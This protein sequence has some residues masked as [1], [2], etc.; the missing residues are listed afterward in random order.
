MDGGGPIRR[1]G[2]DELEAFL[3]A[4]R[5]GSLTEAAATLRI[6]KTAV[7][8]RLRTL[9]ALIGQRLLDRGPRGATL[10]E[11]GRRL[12]PDVQAFL[13]ESER[14]FGRLGDLRANSDSWSISGLRSLSGSGAPSTEQVLRET[15]HLFAEIFH[16]IDDAVAVLDASHGRVLEANR[17]FAQLTGRPREELLGCELEELGIITSSDFG[18]LVADAS[19]ATDRA[20]IVEVRSNRDV[21]QLEFWLRPVILRGE[22]R[23]L[24]V[25]R[26][27][28]SRVRR[29]R[30]LLKR[31]A[32][33]Q[34][35][36]D[37][38]LSVL[39][40]EP[41]PVVF[42]RSAELLATHLDATFSVIWE[43]DGD[44]LLLRSVFGVS[45]RQL[46]ALVGSP[47]SRLSFM[48]ALE[49]DGEVVSDDARRDPRFERESIRAL[50]VRSVAAFRAGASGAGLSFVVVASDET[51]AFDS[52]DLDFARAVAN[53]VGL[54]VRS[55]RRLELERRQKTLLDNFTAIAEVSS[56]PTVLLSLD[57]A[58]V[59]VNRA[60]RAFRRRTPDV[61]PEGAMFYDTLDRRAAA[62]L[63]NVIFPTTLREGRWDG[64]F[65][66]VRPSGERYPGRLTTILVRDP[67]DGEVRWIAAIFYPSAASSRGRTANA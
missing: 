38:T 41:L 39:A 35:L 50:G 27:V 49:A 44:D 31:A 36:A 4:A 51:V 46:T 5:L 53:V 10:T 34:T 28:T 66:V 14:L 20:R 47:E 60:A 23:L 15:E 56:N 64:Q 61:D 8:K 21:R 65:T 9:E 18:A 16:S 3:L 30:R 7:A 45:R 1:P 2:L 42:K 37:L 19:E 54:A 24:G 13:A 32:Q 52:T 40:G 59:Y 33:Q 63:R 55:E 25:G 17:P 22:Q 58:F 11:H 67:A 57:G 12:L 29:E 43:I 48:Q 6:S 26:D 62:R